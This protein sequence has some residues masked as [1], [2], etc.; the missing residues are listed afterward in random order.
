M[1]FKLKLTLF[2]IILSLTIFAQKESYTSNSNK[3]IKH[4]ELAKKYYNAR[5]DI[6]AMEELNNAI[7]IDKLFVEPYLLMANIFFEQGDFKSELICYV[8]AIEAKPDYSPNVYLF[9]G[10]CELKTAKYKEAK[11]HFEGCLAFKDLPKE[12]R[13]MVTDKFKRAEFAMN[14]MKHPVPFNPINLGENI[15][16]TYDEYWPSLSADEQTLVITRLVESD[17]RFPIT[18]R[19]NQQEDFFISY[20]ID[21]E[22][23]DARNIG[24]PLNTI[25]NEGAQTLSV[26]GQYMYFAACNRNDGFGMCDIYYSERNGENWS[27]GINIGPPVNT[28]AWES[29]P[30]ISSDGKTLYFTSGRK[31]GKGEHDIWKSELNEDGTWSQPENLGDSINTTGKEMCP[32]IHPDNQTLY[33]SSNGWYGM[34]GEDIFMSRKKPDGTW[35]TPINL[36]YPINS[37]NDETG[38]IVNAKG[39]LAMFTSDRVTTEG[40]NNGK[41]IYQFDLYKKVRPNTVTYVKGIVYDTKTKGKLK[42]RFELIDLETSKVIIQSYS[43]QVTGEYLVCLPINKNYALNVS[44]EGYLF[45]SANFSLKNL[46]DPSKP[47][48]LDVPLQPIEVGKTTVLRNI[49]FDTDLFELKPQSIAELDKL[50]KFLKLNPTIKVE[51]S[52]HTDNVGSFEHNTLLSQNRAKS[53]YEYLIAKSIVKDRLSYAGY[54]S[55]VPIDSNNTEFGRANNRRTEFKIISVK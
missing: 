25:N 17:N 52:G 43:D 22:W 27:K 18:T 19:N 33:F 32:F 1:V 29:Q 5:N 4:F 50:V 54:S 39:N 55:S 47:Y 10:E 7:I 16:S 14:A 23:T 38:L 36:G 37:E 31:G 26:D 45:Y 46:S 20:K 42:A 6:Q 41:D 35:T 51:I 11:E 30:S 49:F 8:K 40:K 34:G 15:N 21:G 28:G 44:K 48:K 2:L 12:M 53:V 13:E 3:A 24:K 9:A